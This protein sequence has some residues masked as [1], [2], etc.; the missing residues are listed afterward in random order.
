LNQLDYSGI[1]EQLNFREKSKLPPVQIVQAA[2]KW[3]WQVHKGLPL[4]NPT[5]AAFVL[6]QK[7]S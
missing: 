7:H 2:K 4:I 1:K 5:Q 3:G 6:S